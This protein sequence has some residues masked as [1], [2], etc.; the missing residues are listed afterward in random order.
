MFLKTHKI[1]LLFY[2]SP[3][4]TE[5]AYVVSDYCNLQGWRFMLQPFQLIFTMYLA[6]L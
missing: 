5:F 3:H 4:G 1:E 2:L 6:N